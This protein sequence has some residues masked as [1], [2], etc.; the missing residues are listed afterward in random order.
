MFDAF[1]AYDA[2]LDAATEAGEGDAL[3]PQ[4]AA[5]LLGLPVTSFLGGD[6]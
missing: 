1:D 4:E 6:L 2:A 5:N 3:D